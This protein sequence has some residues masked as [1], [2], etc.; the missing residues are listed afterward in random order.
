MK[1][2]DR[3]PAARLK[4]PRLLQCWIHAGAPPVPPALRSPTSRAARRGPR[5]YS[6]HGRAI[7]PSFLSAF[8]TQD[9]IF[10]SCSQ[11]TG[12]FAFWE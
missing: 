8:S 4:L 6:S 7:A 2:L 11:K 1:R 9:F 5:G 3:S 10:P 12:F